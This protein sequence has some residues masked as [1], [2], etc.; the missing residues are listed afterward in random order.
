MVDRPRRRQRPRYGDDEPE[1]G[2]SMRAPGR[3]E[4]EGV[5]TMVCLTC[6]T[7]YYFGSESPPDDL[8]CEKCGNM[9]F[10]SFYSPETEDEVVIDFMDETER[11]LHPDDP[12]G[13]ALP[14]DILDLNQD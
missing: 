8:V 2:E 4:D 12:E 6:G 13:D 10:R 3:G 11:D 5:L 14:G 9:V 1:Y 7:E